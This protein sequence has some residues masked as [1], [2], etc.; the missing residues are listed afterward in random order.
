MLEC[1]GDSLGNPSFS[2]GLM[3]RS[4]GMKVKQ[5]ISDQVSKSEYSYGVAKRLKMD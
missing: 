4:L 3:P 1:F 5:N 2:L